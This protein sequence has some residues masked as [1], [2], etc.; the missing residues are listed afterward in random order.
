MYRSIYVAY[1]DDKK[2]EANLT[3]ILATCNPSNI[4]KLRRAQ[5]SLIIHCDS[6]NKEYSHKATKIVSV[7]SALHPR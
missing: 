7:W 1:I 5:L 6:D 3:E 2:T 4:A